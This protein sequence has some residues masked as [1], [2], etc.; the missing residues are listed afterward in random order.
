M[1]KG[2]KSLKW[3]GARHKKKVIDEPRRWNI[4]RGDKVVVVGNAH[5]CK[6]QTGIVQHVLRKKMRIIVEGVNVG[7]RMLY[8]KADPDRIKAP[9]QAPRSI[10]YSNV[11]IV[12]PITNLPTRVGYRELPDKTWARV[13]LRSG[14]IIDPPKWDRKTKRQVLV[15]TKDTDEDAVL[16]VTYD[17]NTDLRLWETSWDK[18]TRGRLLTN[19]YDFKNS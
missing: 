13:A 14:A 8:D 17:A 15:G 9:V 2:P 18:A 11:N 1:E 6:G 19:L 5:H 10:H 7:T 12:C 4:K 3:A 16:E